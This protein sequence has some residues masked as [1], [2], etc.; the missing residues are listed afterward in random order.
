MNEATLLRHL[1]DYVSQVPSLKNVED[2]IN[3]IAQGASSAGTALSAAQKYAQYRKHLLE[4]CTIYDDKYKPSQHH[5]KL[6]YHSQHDDNIVFD[7]LTDIDT[8]EVYQS[9]SE[10]VEYDHSIVPTPSTPQAFTHQFWSLHPNLLSML[11]SI[12]NNGISFLLWSNS[13]GINFHLNPR[14]LL[15]TE[16]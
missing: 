4:A 2:T 6:N 10:P 3:I 1:Q 12:D 16:F 13:Y 7:S 5:Q 14:L 8:I 11:C 15:L 9:Y